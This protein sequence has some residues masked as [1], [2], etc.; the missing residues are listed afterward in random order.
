MLGGDAESKE[1]VQVSSYYSNLQRRAS[2]RGGCGVSKWANESEHKRALGKEVKIR[3]RAR[4]WNYLDTAHALFLW[5][6][7]YAAVLAR[8]RS[9][10]SSDASGTA[11][12]RVCV[13]LC[14]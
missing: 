6:G 8:Y 14:E 13:L 4:L 3:V 10:Y 11:L 1:R 7:R 9:L 5:I 2:A 12:R